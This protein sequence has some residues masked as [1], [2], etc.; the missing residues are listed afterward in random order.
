M[1][2]SFKADIAVMPAPALQLFSQCALFESACK[3]VQGLNDAG[4]ITYFAG[5]SVRDVL[6]GRNCKDIDI[7]TSATPDEV[8]KVFPRVT[9]IQGKSF[10]VVRVIENEYMFEVATFRTDGAYLDGRRPER[11]TFAT[12]GEDA[13]RRD[14][15]INGLFFD[16]L[17]N[18][19]ID[20]VKG[21]DDLSAGIVR[22][23]GN[24]QKRFKED[25]L[26][27]FRAIRFSSEFGFNIEQK[28][29]EALCDMSEAT[30][31]PNHAALAPERVRDEL[32]KTFTGSGPVQALDQL[33][34]SGLLKLWLP[35]VAELKGVEQPPQFHP[36]GDVFVHTRLML[37]LMNETP[38]L[39]VVFGVLFHDI[40]KPPTKKIDQTGRI[41]FNEHEI[42]GA[43]MTEELMKRLRFSNDQIKA[44]CAL[45][46]GHMK[47]KD[48]PK[49]RL[50]TL[51]RFLAQPYFEDE[52]E[53]HRIDCLGSHADLGIYDFIKEKRNDFIHEEVVPP[54]L[55]TGK[56]LIKLGMHSGP[57][58][59]KILRQLQDEQ[60]EG[61]FK[62]KDDALVRA[63]ELIQN[64]S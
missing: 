56:E 49:M 59:G 4:F 15:T 18:Q 23:I 57:A 13:F 33:D 51:K 46:A 22:A 40:G 19:V 62:N 31:K 21:R 43:R 63:K 45:V 38:G 14:F 29:W 64:I 54:P 9:D 39:N 44:V 1:S 53:L 42:V 25:R 52:L 41:R 20:F 16:P 60:L 47:F 27:L 6:L 17:S 36:E 50:S 35:E 2:E 34:E 11:V 24:P 28:T 10:G 8:Q 58:M 48:A 61:L 3:I 7:A 5:G 12:P 32:I 55:V 30:L 37:E 26:R